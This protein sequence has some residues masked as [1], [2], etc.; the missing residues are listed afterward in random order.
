[1][2]NT[3]L[4]WFS[5]SHA[6]YHMTQTAAL[7]VDKYKAKASSEATA[8]A[9]P[10][11]IFVHQTPNRWLDPANIFL[12]SQA[13][14]ELATE[15]EV[16]R[17]C[18]LYLIHPLGIAINFKYNVEM[19]RGM[20]TKDDRCRL[21]LA[22]NIDQNDLDEK[23]PIMI[24]VFKRQGLIKRQ[25]FWNAACSIDDLEDTLKNM[26]YDQTRYAL[27]EKSNAWWFTKQAAAYAANWECRF[28]A[29]CDYKNLIL[30]HFEDKKDKREEKF[31]RISIVHQDA[32][33][34]NLLGF[35]IQ[36][37]EAKILT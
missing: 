28:V 10:P 7:K 3:I 2:P 17:V 27:E 15:Q 37:C 30:L 4:I 1:M 32:F 19:N 22:F 26:E 5:Q 31:A 34:K 11:R 18:L 6:V 16:V 25:Q 29:F 13:K 33:F 36:A 12:Q 24:V 9:N 8:A 14:A 21:D 35:L 20:K 23:I